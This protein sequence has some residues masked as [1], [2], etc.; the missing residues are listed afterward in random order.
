MVN[1]PP[2][3]LSWQK[4]LVTRVSENKIGSHF[5]LFILVNSFLCLESPKGHSEM[6]L[7]LNRLSNQP[8]PSSSNSPDLSNKE[9]ESRKKR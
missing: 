8:K 7:L 5:S 4:L 6:E 1:Q 9:E 3:Q 2:S